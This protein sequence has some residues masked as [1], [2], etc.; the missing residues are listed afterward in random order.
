MPLSA[1]SSRRL[2]NA[3][4][5]TSLDNKVDSVIIVCTLLMERGTQTT[6]YRSD[7]FTGL[8]PTRIC[9]SAVP[10]VTIISPFNTPPQEYL[11]SFGVAL[12][13]VLIIAFQ[14]LLS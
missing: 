7:V 2:L 9:E 3:G 12:L 14:E 13:V 8:A 5:V 1:K 11:R 4:G 6:S 10:I